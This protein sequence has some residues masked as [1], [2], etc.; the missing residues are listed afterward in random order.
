MIM[1]QIVHYERRDFKVVWLGGARGGLRDQE[2]RDIAQL[3][4]INEHSLPPVDLVEAHF[5]VPQ[6]KLLSIEA[7]P[8]HVVSSVSVKVNDERPDDRFSTHVVQPKC[9]CSP[10]YVRDPC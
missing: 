4:H 9:G 7:Y 10:S 3:V 6:S 5:L 2:V 1:V 8:Y